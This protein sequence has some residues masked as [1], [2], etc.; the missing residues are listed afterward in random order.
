VYAELKAVAGPTFVWEAFPAQLL[1]RL[2]A[3][4]K[5]CRNVKPD[6]SPSRLKW[7]LQDEIADYCEAHPEV[8]RFSAHAFRK[9]AMTEAWRLDISLDKAA[10]AF[11]CNPSTMRAHYIAMEETAV[12]DEVL[13]TIAGAVKPV[14]GSNGPLPTGTVSGEKGESQGQGHQEGA[15]TAG[16]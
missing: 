14:A 10:V 16:G 8:K 7:W 2:T 5:L 11:G 4:G 6:F 9:R 1:E 15:G 12:A 3:L 13:S